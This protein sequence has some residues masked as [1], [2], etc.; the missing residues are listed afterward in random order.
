[1]ALEVTQ[2]DDR[3]VFGLQLI[4]GSAQGVSLGT[5]RCPIGLGATEVAIDADRPDTTA[6][7][8]TALVDDDPI[9]PG[10]ET[11]AIAQFVEPRPC[12]HR[13]VVDGVLG[14][15][16]TTEDERRQAICTKQTL[17]GERLERFA[18]SGQRG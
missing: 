15:T 10:V 7:P 2:H 1:M 14:V 12:E 4:E 11:A 17:I 9:E 18:T 5:A 3:P 6:K 8:L 13:G 16:V